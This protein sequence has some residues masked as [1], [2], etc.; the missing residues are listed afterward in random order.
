MFKCLDGNS[1]GI[2]C[3]DRDKI[4]DTIAHLRLEFFFLN[5]NFDSQDIQQPL[6][7]YMDRDLASG[8]EYNY[9]AR[10]VMNLNQ[11]VAITND[12]YFQYK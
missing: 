2:V 11:N 10:T 5:N 4:V 9:F 7:A 3:K 8:L 12:S 6:E 1:K